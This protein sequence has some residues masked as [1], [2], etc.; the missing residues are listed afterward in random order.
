MKIPTVL[1]CSAVLLAAIAPANPAGAATDW[2]AVHGSECIAAGANTTPAELA[3]GAYG[4]SNPGGA[5]ELVICP[6]PI[7]TNVPWDAST[8][9]TIQVRFRAGNVTGRV[10]CSV[11]NGAAGA[12]DAPVVTATYTSIVQPANSRVSTLDLTIPDPTD[13]GGTFSPVPPISVA[14]LLGPG[15]KLGGLFLDEHVATPLQEH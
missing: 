11:F 8:P 14:C 9:S 3:Y 10:I 13:A 7:D 4:V 2:K 1:A 12:Q 6:L 15:I 5:D